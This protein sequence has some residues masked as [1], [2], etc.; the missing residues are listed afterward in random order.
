MVGGTRPRFLPLMLVVVATGE[1]DVVEDDP[2]VGGVELGE[3][4]QA[5][6]EVGLSIPNWSC[7]VRLPSPAPTETSRSDVHSRVTPRKF[8]FDLLDGGEIGLN[9]FWQGVCKLVLGNAERA[10]VIP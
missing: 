4:G 1:L 9:G 5:G 10:C 2:D 8:A 7:W 3:G 6:Q